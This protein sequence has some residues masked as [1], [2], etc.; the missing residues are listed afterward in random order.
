MCSHYTEHFATKQRHIGMNTRALTHTHAHTLTRS[1]LSRP[2]IM[3]CLIETVFLNMS[4]S[5]AIF[6][7]INMLKNVTFRDEVAEVHT[8]VL[9]SRS[10]QYP[11]LLLSLQLPPLPPLPP[12][13]TSILEKCSI[14]LL[15][16]GVFSQLHSAS[17]I[18]VEHSSAVLCGCS[19]VPRWDWS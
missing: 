3:W 10:A 5:I 2:Q 9:S 7:E 18:A 17:P 13:P 1:P 12:L 19:R 8:S 11:H 6:W 14:L 15:C 16:C 4:Q